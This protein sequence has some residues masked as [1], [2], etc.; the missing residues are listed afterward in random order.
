M[1]KSKKHVILSIVV[2]AVII[3]LVF[4][5]HQL[6]PHS[7]SETDSLES[8][9]ESND[10]ILSQEIVLSVLTNKT[11][12]NSEMFSEYKTQYNNSGRKPLA[13]SLQVS[14][15]SDYS[16]CRV[17]AEL[18]HDRLESN[19][20]RVL[21]APGS[22]VDGWITIEPSKSFKWTFIVLV[23]EDKDEQEVLRVLN[24]NMCTITYEI[25]Y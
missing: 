24:N 17:E 25:K 16:I 9:S 12:S 10:S 8:S 13:F 14:N 3:L 4:S 6:F 18:D 2:A 20:I 22:F 11:A 5:N 7:T 1:N 15:R 19:G 23:Y 21:R